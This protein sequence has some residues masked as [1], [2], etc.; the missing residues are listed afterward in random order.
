MH[1]GSAVLTL[2]KTHPSSAPVEATETSDLYGGIALGMAAVAAL[3][4]ANSP[5]SAHYHDL[6][7][8]TGEIRI[9]AM[10][11]KKTLAHWINDGLMAVYF[12]L[13]AL[14]IKRE[15]LQGSLASARKAALPAIGAVGGFVVPALMYV[16]LNWGDAGALR[17]WAVPSAT[18]IAFA[19]GVCAVLGRVVPSSLKTFLLALAIIDDLMAIIAI[20]VFYTAEL[21]TISLLFAGFGVAGLISLNR[22]GISTPTPYLLVG[23]FTWVCGLE[24]GVHA[25]LAGVAVGFAMPLTR[26]DGESLLERTEHSLKPWANYCIVPIF[27]FANAGVSLSGVSPADLTAS[28][29]LAIAAGLFLGKQLGVFLFATAAMKLAIADRP[30][31]ATLAQLYGITILTGVGFTMSLFIGTLAFEDAATMAQVKLG[32]LVGS[33]LSGATA[34]ILMSVAD[35]AKRRGECRGEG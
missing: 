15:A 3:I 24:S 7:N 16:A 4:V 13:V 9:G 17:G 18:D 1:K 19:L 30:R 27:A 34:A 20:A 12:L 22:A 14:E 31:G 8:T 6:L 11:L 21:S 33:A 10:G 28:I 26:H 5:L 35:R 25:T 23:V 2:S 29:P 32:V